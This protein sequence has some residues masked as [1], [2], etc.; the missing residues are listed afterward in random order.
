MPAT[1]AGAA[2]GQK[3]KGKL[4]TN[5]LVRHVMDLGCG[6]GDKSVFLAK[7]GFSVTG[8]DFA[9]TALKEARAAAEKERVRVTFILADITKIPEL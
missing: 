3:F 9:P 4:G 5:M 2:K 8:V 7:S 6:V 1:V